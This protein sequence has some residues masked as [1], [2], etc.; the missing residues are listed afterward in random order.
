MGLED[1]VDLLYTDKAVEVAKTVY[2]SLCTFTTSTSSSS[3]I[4]VSLVYHSLEQ[5]IGDECDLIELVNQLQNKLAAGGHSLKISLPQIVVV[6]CQSAGKSS[7]LESI[8]GKEF[9]PRGSGVVTRRPAVVQL[10]P[11]NDGE[12]YAVFLHKENEKFTNFE[13]VKNEIQRETNRDPGTSGFSSQPISLKIY[14]P[15]VLKLTLVDLPGLIKNVVGDQAETSIAEVRNMVLQ[16]IEQPNSLILAVSPAN[17]DIANSDALNIA[18]EVDPERERTIGVLTKLDLMDD[19]TN[20]CDILE[21]KKIFLKRGYVGVLNR[22][23]KDIDEQRDIDYSLEKE[24]RYFDET[25]CYKA[26]ADQMGTPYLR[27]ML[28]HQLRIHIKES[29]PA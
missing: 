29:L 10:Q 5:G 23:Q 3:I 11:C 13:D 25:E 15:K 27:K 17:Q 16:Y 20:A 6:G 19:G 14:S 18:K 2:E 7:V 21:N 24:R 9:L 26:L 8:V 22:S 4:S 12:E 28:N 1:R